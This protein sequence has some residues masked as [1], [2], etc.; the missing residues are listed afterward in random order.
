MQYIYSF[1]QTSNRSQCMRVTDNKQQTCVKIGSL[2]VNTE[3]KFLISIEFYFI[4]E[5]GS[6]SLTFIFCDQEVYYINFTV[7]NLLYTVV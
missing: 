4:T 5:V 7:I 2:S 6:D 1:M 3:L